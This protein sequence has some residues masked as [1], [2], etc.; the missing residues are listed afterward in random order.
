MRVHAKSTWER[1]NPPS[2]SLG[3]GS[4]MNVTSEFQT[5][6]SQLRVA[7][8]LAPDLR[9]S[10]SSPGSKTGGRPSLTD[11]IFS[12]S[13]STPMTSKPFAA[14]QAANGAPSFPRPKIEIR[15]ERL[16]EIFPSINDSRLHQQETSLNGLPPSRISANQSAFPASET[17]PA[18]V[19]GN[20]TLSRTDTGRSPVPDREKH[21]SP[22]ALLSQ[23]HSALKGA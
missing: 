8:S 20:T 22:Q 23:N 7:R 4:K 12:S 16:S 9:I 15:C 17:L 1:E 2:F 11:R 18:V 21:A 10:S 6:S 5:A 13:I 19:R 3:V 14:R